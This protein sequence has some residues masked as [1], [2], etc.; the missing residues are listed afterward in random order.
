MGRSCSTTFDPVYWRYCMPLTITSLECPRLYFLFILTFNYHFAWPNWFP[1]SCCLALWS[2]AF[3]T[4]YRHLL[5]YFHQS[6]QILFS[7]LGPKTSPWCSVFCSCS[8][9]ASPCV[10]NLRRVELKNKLGMVS[11][12]PP[13]R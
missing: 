4:W 1:L 3:C 9:S 7:F 5:Y 10:V 13:V 8:T 12:F 2:L 6:F 11:L